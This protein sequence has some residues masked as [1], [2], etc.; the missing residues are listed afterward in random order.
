[1]PNEKRR[2]LTRTIEEVLKLQTVSNRKLAQAAGKL[3]AAAPAVPIAPLFARAVYK[4][5][6]G[7]MGWDQVY[8]SEAAM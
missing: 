6:V 3:I 2:N 5:M 1:M 8:E 4:A 7:K